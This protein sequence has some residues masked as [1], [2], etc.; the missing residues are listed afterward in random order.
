MAG[1]GQQLSMFV[2]PHFLAALL[3]HT[4]QIITPSQQH[5]DSSDITALVNI[6]SNRLSTVFSVRLNAKTG[7]V[8]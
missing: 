6:A 7:S 2:F 1:L 4:T 8:A 3:D 5:H